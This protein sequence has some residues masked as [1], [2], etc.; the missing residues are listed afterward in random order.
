MFYIVSYLA[1]I[2]LNY[3]MKQVSHILFCWR[4]LVGYTHQT[5]Y[6]VGHIYKKKILDN[7]KGLISDFLNSLKKVQPTHAQFISSK[8]LIFFCKTSIRII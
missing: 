2:L 4:S 7:L 5:K 8:H 6:S 3:E 1:K